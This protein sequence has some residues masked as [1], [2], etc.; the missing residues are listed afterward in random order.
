MRR[1]RGRP[2]NQEGGI[3]WSKESMIYRTQ[4]HHFSVLGCWE[5]IKVETRVVSLAWKKKQTV[6]IHLESYSPLQGGKIHFMYGGQIAFTEP[7]KGRLSP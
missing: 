7:A 3:F 4:R 6:N 1:G 5:S 2:A